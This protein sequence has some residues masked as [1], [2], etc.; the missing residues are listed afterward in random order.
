MKVKELKDILDALNP[1]YE[2]YFEYKESNDAN[3]GLSVDGIKAKLDFKHIII[4]HN[5]N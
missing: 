1:D 4:K 3:T 2:V 5:D